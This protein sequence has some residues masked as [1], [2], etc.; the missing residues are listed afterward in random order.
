MLLV[1]TIG[2]FDFIDYL[3]VFLL[4]PVR[5]LY[6]IAS[7]V[8]TNPILMLLRRI[9]PSIG[10]LTYGVIITVVSPQRL[11]LPQFSGSAAAVL[12]L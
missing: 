8:R 12:F 9:M 6:P 10:S 1:N 3:V 5:R 11:P 7:F 2:S 4:Q